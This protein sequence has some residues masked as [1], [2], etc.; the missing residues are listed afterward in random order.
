MDD[1]SKE[2]LDKA[3]SEKENSTSESDE[4]CRDLSTLGIPAEVLKGMPPD[5]KKMLLSTLQVSMQ[6][7]FPGPKNPIF[8]KIDKDHISKVLELAH[9]EDERDFK[10]TINSIGNTILFILLQKAFFRPNTN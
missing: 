10:K 5:A 8:D 9:D 7:V 1:N 6:G 4:N 3:S 2:I